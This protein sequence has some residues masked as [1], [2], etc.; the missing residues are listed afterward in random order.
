MR[1]GSTGLSP[2]PRL[3]RLLSLSPLPF[4]DSIF[5]H[6]CSPSPQTLSKHLSP[7]RN[8]G[9]R[10]DTLEVPEVGVPR[11][12]AGA[13]SHLERISQGTKECCRAREKNCVQLEG[14]LSPI[15]GETWAPMALWSCPTLRQGPDPWTR[16][17]LWTPMAG[18]GA[19][20]QHPWLKAFSCM[21]SA[22]SISSS[23]DHVLPSCCR[24]LMDP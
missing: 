13:G 9:K 2:S 14:S 1:R 7:T 18:K 15:L 3:P 19:A 24:K 16:E 12:R 11:G 21:A 10:P 8:P 23:W 22:A 4:S 6:S 20:A 17:L 5:C